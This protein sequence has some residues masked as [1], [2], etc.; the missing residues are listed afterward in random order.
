M[1]PAVQP[2][3]W[4]SPE[5]KTGKGLLYVSSY[6]SNFVSIYKQK[7]TNQSP[8]G[9]ITAGLS[10]P[11]GMAV[12][13]KLN[14]YVA[15]TSN[16]TVTVYPPGQT[17][18]STTYS[19]SLSEPAGVAVGTDGTVYVE[20]LGNSIVEY[21]AGSTSPSHVISA[22]FPIDAALDSS[23][24]LYV[25]YDFCCVEKFAPGSTTGTD[26]GIV[27]SA[28]GGIQIDGS[29][30]VVVANQVNT[31]MIEVFPPGQTSPSQVFGQEGDPNPI[32]FDHKAKH[33]YVGEPTSSTVN[34]YAY[35]SGTK[36]NTITSGV[37]F[38]AGVALSPESKY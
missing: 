22:T 17:S 31:P 28:N 29:N 25:T 34:V 20:N 10:G 33:L 23:N 1:H 30:N 4:L 27:L 26:L 5:A 11:E 18:P 12:D 9:T 6:N 35:P 7:G 14:L 3:A 8:I 21:P 37:D 36:V 38:P 19:Q 2:R 13:R 15:N 16:N 32:R 24:N